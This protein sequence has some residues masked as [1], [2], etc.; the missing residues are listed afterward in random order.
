VSVPVIEVELTLL[1]TSEGGRKA[2][3]NLKEYDNLRYMPHIVIGDATQRQPIT[4]N[5]NVII[6]KYLGVSWRRENPKVAPGETA[7]VL[8]DLMYYPHL[9]Y[10]EVTPGAEFTLRE[11]GQVVGY[12]R[13][14]R[15]IV[16]DQS[17]ND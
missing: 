11:G 6:E 10:H 12:G 16:D 15:M 13:V 2:P 9:D 8:L 1:P 14:R 17:A 4:I 7:V 3:V 5:G